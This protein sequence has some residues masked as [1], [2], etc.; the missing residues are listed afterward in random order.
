MAVGPQY[1]SQLALLA[2]ALS[3]GLDP[4]QGYDIYNQTVQAAQAAR[5]QRQQEI[6]QSLGALSQM[7]VQAATSGATPEQVGALVHASEAGLPHQG[8]QAIQ[9][10][11]HQIMG[12]L[13]DYQ[14]TPDP[15]AQLQLQGAQLDL[16]QKQ[17]DLAN[18]M[19]QAP[20]ISAEQGIYGPAHEQLVQNLTQQYFAQG[21]PAP[22]IRAKIIAQLGPEFTQDVKVPAT[23]TGVPTK[24]GQ[25]VPG[26]KM[27]DQQMVT[28]GTPGLIDK[29]ISM[30]LAQVDPSY[31]STHPGGALATAAGLN[32]PAAQASSSQPTLTGQDVIGALNQTPNNFG[33]GMLNPNANVPPPPGQ[34]PQPPQG[35]PWLTALATPLELM[36]G[37]FGNPGGQPY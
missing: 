26:G 14:A 25:P 4:T 34:A 18:S 9:H 28:P 30:T 8:S 35:N 17:V 37:A 1:Q 29:T 10:G 22:E 7:A 33:I 21:M 20:D 32:P 19:N 5:A 6:Q 36:R 27:I 2:G 3:H 11:V 24:S 31:M 13:S 16:Q 12:S 15:M 23:P